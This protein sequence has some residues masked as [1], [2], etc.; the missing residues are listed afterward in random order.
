MAAYG[1]TA[2]GL[3][4]SWGSQLDATIPRPK[5]PKSALP[6]EIRAK[7]GLRDGRGEDAESKAYFKPG[8]SVAEQRGAR[9]NEYCAGN[10]KHFLKRGSGRV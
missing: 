6:P 3:Q 5:V 8:N 10:Q 4:C 2:S 1:R 9:T 7:L